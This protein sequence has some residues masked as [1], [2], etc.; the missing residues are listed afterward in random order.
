MNRMQFGGLCL[1]VTTLCAGCSGNDERPPGVGGCT[2]VL[3]GKPGGG[4]V[5]PRPDGGQPEAA[6]DGQQAD[7]DAAPISTVDLSGSIV[8]LTEEQFSQEVPFLGWGY[9]RVPTVSG[10][11]QVSFGG[12]AGVGFSATGV[13]SGPG[14]FTVVPEPAF[15]DLVIP[16]HAYLIAPQQASSNFTVPVVDR[17]LLTSIYASLSPPAFVRADAS[18]VIVVFEK[19][20]Q[21]VAGVSITTHP[22]A[23]AIAYDQGVGYST[24]GTETGVNGTVLL[25]N[26]VGMSPLRWKDNTGTDGS[27]TLVHVIGQ[28]SFVRID[29]S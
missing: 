19:N 12:E 2:D 10:D 6:I 13:V 18:H 17:D 22:T 7:V 3:C 15:Y 25:V 29:L 28:V 5:N 8:R 14:W 4:T 1:A 16:T 24:E 27:L 23:E 26:V 11:D 9:L 20:G 21:R